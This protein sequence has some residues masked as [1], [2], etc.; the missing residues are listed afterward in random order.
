MHKSGAIHK[1]DLNHNGDYNTK[2]AFLFESY[3]LTDN[4]KVTYKE[5]AEIENGSW[6]VSY[7]ILDDQLWQDICDGKFNGISPEIIPSSVTNNGVTKQFNEM[8]TL[9]II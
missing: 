1:I 6:I 5:F 2:R 7:K 9:I 8:K 4:H 3:I